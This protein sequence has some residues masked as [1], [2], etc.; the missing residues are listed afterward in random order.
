MARHKTQAAPF[1]GLMA[2]AQVTLAPSAN[3]DR[4]FSSFV[5]R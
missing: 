5:L 2:E 1:Y 4:F 3:F